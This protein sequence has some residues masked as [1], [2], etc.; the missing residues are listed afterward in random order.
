MN[1]ILVMQGVQKFMLRYHDLA[2]EMHGRMWQIQI[3]QE[4]VFICRFT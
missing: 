3:I 1:F 2:L 4:M